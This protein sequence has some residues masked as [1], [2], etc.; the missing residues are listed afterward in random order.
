MNEYFSVISF[1]EEMNTLN[2]LTNLRSQKSILCIRSYPSENM[3]GNSLTKFVYRLTMKVFYNS[4]NLIIAQTD[5]MKKR[6]D[7]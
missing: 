2:V 6:F 7:K 5:S 3:K 1:M 4:S